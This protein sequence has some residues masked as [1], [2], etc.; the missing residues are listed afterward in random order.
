MKNEQV[1]IL[2]HSQKPFNFEKIIYRETEFEYQQVDAD[3]DVRVFDATGFQNFND[4]LANFKPAR[5]PSFVICRDDHLNQ[6]LQNLPPNEPA[7]SAR[8]AEGNM[9]ILLARMLL[10]QKERTLFLRRTFQDSLTAA[11]NRVEFHHR[12]G[13]ML[14]LASPERPVGL[15]LVGID[16]MKRVNDVHGHRV[17]DGLLKALVRLLIASVNDDTAVFRLSGDEFAVVA[18]LDLVQLKALAEFIRQEMAETEFE[19]YGKKVRATVSIGVAV[20]T[21]ELSAE[22]FTQEADVALYQAKA[23]GR[24]QVVASSL[25][26]E[27]NNGDSVDASL[28]DFENRVRVLTDRLTAVLTHKTRQLVTQLKREAEYDGLTGLFTKRYFTRRM[29]REYDRAVRMNS[30]LSLIFIDIDHFGQVNKTYGFPTGDRALQQVTG[31]L[32]NSIRTVDWSARYGGEELCVIL[33]DTEEK[34]ALEVARRIWEN[35]G[36]SQVRSF[37]GKDFSLTIS[38]GVAEIRID[39]GEELP[40]FIQRCSDRTR[41]AKENGRNQICLVDREEASDEK[42]AERGGV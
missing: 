1:K 25:D 4:G 8:D 2:W 19:L 12:L 16:K 22:L 40:D 20:N 37:N 21:G 10:R 38:V 35:V 36:G 13:F 33:P 7:V 27:G 6:W 26:Y 5:I 18:S 30:P 23:A 29:G 11:L 28:Q 15:L 17:G 31:I 9:G 24:N 14:S 39:E 3:G 42:A 34:E 32:K 41:R